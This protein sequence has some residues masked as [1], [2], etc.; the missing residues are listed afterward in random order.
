[1]IP[2]LYETE[3]VPCERKVIHEVWIY[4]PAGAYW[5]IAEKNDDGLAFGFANLGDDNNAEWGYIQLNELKKLKIQ[6]MSS[7]PGWSDSFPQA[8]QFVEDFLRLANPLN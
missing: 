4:P 2:K 3:D 1:M 8:K 7:P 6:K 5:L